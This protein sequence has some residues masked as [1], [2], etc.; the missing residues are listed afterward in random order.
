MDEIDVVA[1]RTAKALDW[2]R[3]DKW[4]A[5]ILAN[6]IAAIAAVFQRHG[7]GT[8]EL[9]YT[10]ESEQVPLGPLRFLATHWHGVAGDGALPHIREID[11]FKLRP[12]LGYL[13]VLDPLDGGR[14]FRY[15]LYGS[16]IARIS[17]LDMTGRKT[18]EHP[19]SSYVAEFNIA[20][21]RAALKARVPI[22]STRRPVGAELTTR[23]HR[24]SLPFA[25]DSGTPVRIVAGTAAIDSAGRMVRG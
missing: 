12:A 14:D 11:P 5:L 24:L 13:M 21:N 20:I 10:P 8:P 18:S 25:D 1:G 7:A 22:Y 16:A 3:I 9:V 15:R 6:D 23:W 2:S 4:T 17:G 19:A